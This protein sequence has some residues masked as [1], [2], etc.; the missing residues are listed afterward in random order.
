MKVKEK[1]F[2]FF[3]TLAIIIYAPFV[4]WV[5]YF[6]N[7]YFGQI[8]IEVSKARHL[9][10][11]LVLIVVGLLISRTVDYLFNKADSSKE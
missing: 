7:Q 10:F 5:G 8:V 2:M 6:F 4:I 1:T 3:N 11:I 9:L